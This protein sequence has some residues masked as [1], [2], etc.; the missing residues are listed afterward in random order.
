MLYLV[1]GMS[2]V[3]GRQKPTEV[4]HLVVFEPQLETVISR[5][6]TQDDIGFVTVHRATNKDLAHYQKELERNHPN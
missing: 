3:R 1:T 2:K 4:T 6:M 5:L